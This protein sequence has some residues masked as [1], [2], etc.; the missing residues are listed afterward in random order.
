MVN[1]VSRNWTP[2]VVVAA[3]LAVS[4]EPAQAAG[5]VVLRVDL[6]NYVQYC[7]NVS[8]YSKL[9]SDASMVPCSLSWES[10]CRQDVGVTRTYAN[11]LISY[12]EEFGPNYFHLGSLVR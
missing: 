2:L 11:R 7:G 1:T 5:L 4:P 10:Y 8:D 3:C 12:L 6:E 9:A